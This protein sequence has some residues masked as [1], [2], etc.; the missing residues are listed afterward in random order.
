[1]NKKYLINYLDKNQQEYKTEV[2]T[3]EEADSLAE[4]LQEEGFEN[5]I[6]EEALE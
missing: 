4:E 1:M 3:R 6:I 2:P 5:I